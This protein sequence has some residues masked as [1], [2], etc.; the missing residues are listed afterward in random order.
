MYSETL[1]N[2]KILIRDLTKKSL[3]NNVSIDE[4]YNFLAVNFSPR[5]IYNPK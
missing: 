1:K 3:P 4:I 5:I 2:Y